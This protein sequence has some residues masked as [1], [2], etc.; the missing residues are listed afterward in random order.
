MGPAPYFMAAI[1]TASCYS[2]N[3]SNSAGT[4][5]SCPGLLQFHSHHCVLQITHS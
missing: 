2:D 1:P 5:R 4:R 3:I